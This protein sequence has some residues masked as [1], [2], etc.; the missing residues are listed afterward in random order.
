MEVGH[1][2]HH[3]M[4]R[5]KEVLTN[6]FLE[7]PPEELDNYIKILTLSEEEDSEMLAKRFEPID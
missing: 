5:L 7:A 3:C 1:S 2:P 6:R 4:E